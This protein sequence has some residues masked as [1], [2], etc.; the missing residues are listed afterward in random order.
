MRLATA[1]RPE[2]GTVLYAA[3]PDGRFFDVLAAA[4]D[5]RSVLEGVTDVGSLYHAGSTAV[6]AVQGLIARAR[7]GSTT[8]VAAD[9][10]DLAPPVTNPRAIV[11]I[12]RNYMA[13]IK[14]GDSPIP[15]FPL[16]FSKYVNTLV[17][18]G[19][20]VIHHAITNELDY[21]GELGVI[22]GRRARHVLEPDALEYVAG[23]TIVNDISAR[24]LQL[25][26][27]QW[28]R[29]K[30]LDTFCPVGPLFVSR[31]EIADVDRLQIQTRVNGELRQDAPASDM[32][33]K[34]PKLIEFITEGITLEPGD[35]ILT[36]TP[37]GVA[38]GMPDPV[39]LKAGDVV[40]ITITDLGTLRSVIVAP[41]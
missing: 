8:T 4:G 10:L 24:D 33:F 11:C 7:A 22:I 26:D 38:F 25:G 15:A 36:G 18:H 2:G 12:G 17:G 1:N 28:I 13:H 20:E 32:I 31:D 29:G 16:L 30:S 21:E 19:D 14:E 37:S 5:L 34:V 39:Y 41:R 27:P 9:D 23:Y 6:G 3:T 35:L 40:E